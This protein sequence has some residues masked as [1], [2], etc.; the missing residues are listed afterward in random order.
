[1]T[2]LS[3]IIC[4]HNPDKERLNR[5]LVGLQNQTLPLNKW[6]LIIVDNNSSVPVAVNLNWHSAARIVSEPKTGLTYAR[7]KGFAESVGKIIVLVDDDNILNETYLLNTLTIFNNNPRLGCIG[8]K[9]VPEFEEQQPEW[10]TAFYGLLAIRDEGEHEII[11][12]W[13]NEYPKAAPVGA[14]MGIRNEAIKSYIDKINNY[15]GAITDRQGD[16]L[17][18]GG[19]ND[20]VLEVLKQNWQAGYFPSLSLTHIIPAGRMGVNYLARLNQSSNQSW[21]KVLQQHGI[22]PWSKSS[23]WAKPLRKLKAWFTYKAWK[24]SVQYIKWSGA[25]GMYDA[26]ADDK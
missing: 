26:L 21:I 20:M 7:L 4:T 1:M 5:T 8:G 19:D 25:C 2:E 14:G 12:V 6:E 16:S 11:N 24:S 15:K 10:L 9:I 22:S 13:A 23:A 18:S 3:V 17:S